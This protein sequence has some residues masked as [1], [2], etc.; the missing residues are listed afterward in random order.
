M[1]ASIIPAMPLTKTV[2]V[3]PVKPEFAQTAV[4]KTLR[5][6]AYCRVSTDKDE[7]QNSYAAQK[8]FYTQKIMGNPEWQMAGIYAEANNF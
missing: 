2:R 5:V 8:S 7:Q 4:K 1:Q 6:A 3:I